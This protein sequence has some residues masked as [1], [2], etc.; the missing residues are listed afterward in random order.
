MQGTRGEGSQTHHRSNIHVPTPSPPF[1]YR[2]AE[3]RSNP[4]LL[5]DCNVD[6][7]QF[8]EDVHQMM[9]GDTGPGDLYRARS[10]DNIFGF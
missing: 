7:G 1:P 6:G 5:D 3:A 2:L 8:S 4:N 10:L 9:Q